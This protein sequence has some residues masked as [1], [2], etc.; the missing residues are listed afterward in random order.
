MNITL[1]YRIILFSFRNTNKLSCNIYF[2]FHRNPLTRISIM[3]YTTAI[4]GQHDQLHQHQQDTKQKHHFIVQFVK[5]NIYCILLC[6]VWRLYHIVCPTYAQLTEYSNGSSTVY[7]CDELCLKNF[8]LRVIINYESFTYIY[9][10]KY[11]KS[12]L[13]YKEQFA[14]VLI[15]HLVNYKIDAPTTASTWY[16]CKV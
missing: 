2:S 16:T 5:W 15:M 4:Y 9:R 10:S 14:S 13:L 11:Y 6:V 12:L 3:T 7:A 1:I 8:P